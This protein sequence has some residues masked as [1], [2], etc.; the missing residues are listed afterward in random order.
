MPT[1]PDSLRDFAVVWFALMV[2]VHDLTG[3][4]TPLALL[5]ALT[6]GVP[7]FFSPLAGALVDRWNRKLL[8]V[9]SDST[10]GLAT[11]GGLG[12]VPDLWAADLASVSNW[13]S[14]GDL[15]TFPVPCVRRSGDH[16]GSQHAL[17]SDTNTLP[18]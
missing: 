5:G 4:A 2:W 12:P 16:D 14:R 3:Q 7:I 11:I 10:A 18:T 6:F 9:L 8:L 17:C 13:L 1:P 15:P